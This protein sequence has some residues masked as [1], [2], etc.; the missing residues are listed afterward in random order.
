MTFEDQT[1]HQ[2]FIKL[3]AAEDRAAEVIETHNAKT[4]MDDFKVLYGPEAVEADKAYVVERK[5]GFRADAE[6]LPTDERL[7]QERGARLAYVLEAIVVNQRTWL[8]MN[9]D[10]LPT[11]PYDN[12]KNGVDAI[13]EHKFGNVY[14]HG[15][16]AMDV[17]SSATQT[18]KKLLERLSQIR[19]GHLATVKYFHSPEAE[20]RSGLSEIPAVVIG[21]SGDT[22]EELINL[23]A[24]HEDDSLN[25]HPVQFQFIEQ[26]IMQ[27]EFFAQ[28]AKENNVP[29]AAAIIA[30]YDKLATQMRTVRKQKNLVYKN[31]DQK[32]IRDKFHE[33]M[34]TTLAGLK[35]ATHF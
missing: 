35:E 15:G 10:I 6:A 13:L 2:E 8:G 27:A 14:T 18:S 23:F 20:I 9:A 22:M 16:L 32:N 5:E 26:I 31:E 12:F 19:T 34:I 28:Y 24:S 30:A 21:A 3:P 1:Q 4:N 17:T 29:N 33:D 7:W 25:T 11:S